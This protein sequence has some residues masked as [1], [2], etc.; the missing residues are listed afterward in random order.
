M[1]MTD[2]GK[3]SALMAAS[4]CLAVLSVAYGTVLEPYVSGLAETARRRERYEKTVTEKGLSL[5]QGMYW[6]EKD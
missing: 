5:H 6:K 3:F 2:S 1:G 4:V